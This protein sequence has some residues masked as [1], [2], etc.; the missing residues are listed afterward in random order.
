MTSST[1]TQS[2]LNS[3]RAVKTSRWVKNWL[4]SSTRQ[5]RTPTRINPLNCLQQTRSLIFSSAKLWLLQATHLHLQLWFS[6]QAMEWVKSTPLRLLL[7]KTVWQTFT[8]SSRIRTS[9]PQT[10][11]SNSKLN[12]WMDRA[13]A[14]SSLPWLLDTQRSSLSVS[15]P[16]SHRSKSRSLLFRCFRLSRVSGTQLEWLTAILLIFLFC[17]LTIFF[18]RERDWGWG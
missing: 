8:L 10:S 4:T 14:N 17:S 1:N 9:T 13:K 12:L 7:M 3:H 2:T 16:L 11:V 18:R 5:S 15:R 6:P